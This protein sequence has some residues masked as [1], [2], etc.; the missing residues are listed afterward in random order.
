[1]A[2][3]LSIPTD[4]EGFWLLKCPFCGA[5]FKL[6]P[7]DV[8]DENVCNIYCPS[9]GLTGDNYLT[10]EIIKIAKVQTENAFFDLI[11]KD[12]KRIEQQNRGNKCVTLKVGNTPKQKENQ[13]IYSTIDELHINYYPCCNKYAKID[14]LIKMSAKFCPFCGGLTLDMNETDFKVLVSDYNSHAS[15][16]LK[17]SYQDY[18]HVVKRFTRFLDDHETIRKFIDNCGGYNTDLEE[19]VVKAIDKSDNSGLYGDTDEEEVCIIYTTL[20]YIANHCSETPLG[21]IFSYSYAG[22][23]E[24]NINDFNRKFVSILIQHISDYLKREGIKMGINDNSSSSYYGSNVV[25]N[26][27][28]DNGT[29]NVAQSINNGA[30][31]EELLKLLSGMR[32]AVSSDLS[33]DD[34]KDALE[35]ISAIESELKKDKP[36]EDNIKTHFKLLK[37]IDK[38]TAF[39]KSCAAFLA[40]AQSLHPFLES[41]ISWFQ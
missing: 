7:K 24:A 19:A 18:I 23:F 34:K 15:R 33:A 20:K 11:F 40:A 32:N 36:N 2:V 39:I 8:K 25:Y 28:C 31:S 9:C 3:E 1:M 38:G 22:N 37:R 4:E 29:I 17:T 35:S 6:L 41:I 26:Q 10:D 12:L 13:F 30:N 27:V 5:L 16:L 14:S 21:L